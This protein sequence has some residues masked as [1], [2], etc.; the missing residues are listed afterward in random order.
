MSLASI[1]PLTVLAWIFYQLLHLSLACVV[2]YL[3]YVARRIRPFQLMVWGSTFRDNA[4]LNILVIFLKHLPI[5]TANSSSHF[6][7][8]HFFTC[9]NSFCF[10][11][12]KR[13]CPF[14]LDLCHRRSRLPCPSTPANLRPRVRS[15]PHSPV[16]RSPFTEG[17]Q[18]RK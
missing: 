14:R 16:C 18:R 9:L 4:F 8:H 5:S 1:Q 6:N 3:P 15:S 7:L 10:S 11:F 2:A 17:F 12:Q 13:R